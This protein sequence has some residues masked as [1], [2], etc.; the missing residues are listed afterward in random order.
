MD[1]GRI[2]INQLMAAMEKGDPVMIFAGYP[3]EM[4]DFLNSNPGLKSRIKY[5]FNFPDYSVSELATI[6]EN[7]IAD[8]GFRFGG[9]T[10]LVEILEQ[11]TT[12][13][14]RSEQNGRL[15]KNIVAE[16]VIN[17][18]N[19]LSFTDDGVKLVTLED[20]DVIK[21]C[22][23]FCDVPNKDAQSGEPENTATENKE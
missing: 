6:L 5:K 19:R 13:Q 12:V 7:G 9:E 17:L 21:A 23:A 11:E 14:I 18:S 16:A 15:A 1:Y 22:R 20:D 10:S 3:A 8:S 4:K 2:A